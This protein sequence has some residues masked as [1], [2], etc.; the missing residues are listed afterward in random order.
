MTV[1]NPLSLLCYQPNFLWNGKQCAVVLT[2]DDGLVVHLTNVI[3]LL[4]SVGFKGTFYIPPSFPDFQRHVEEWKRVAATGHELGNHTL[5]HPCNSSLPGREWVPM[6]YRLECYSMKRISDEI[7][8]ANFIL[9]TLDGKKSRTFAYTCGDRMVGTV[10]YHEVIEYNF[11]AARGVGGNGVTYAEIDKYNIPSVVV[12]GQSGDELIAHVENA[13]QNNHLVVFLFHGVGGGH[14]YN[15]SLDA[16]RALISY[17]NQRKNV[18][19]V[20]PLVEVAEFLKQ[21]VLVR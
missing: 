4:D 12:N 19:W 16:H 10:S 11:P 20:A 18:I 21:K 5:F 1:V 2:Y 6:E 15:C 7:E 8:L 14:A 9:T 3:P 13:L 17:L